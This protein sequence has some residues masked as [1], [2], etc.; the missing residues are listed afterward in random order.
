MT[1]KHLVFSGGG[2]I[3]IQYLAALQEL[4]I[5][6]HIDIANIETIYGTSAGAMLAVIISLKFDWDTINDY[7]IKRPWH[8][9][10]KFTVED[11][12]NAFNT[13]GIF[14]NITIIKCFE[15]LFKAK[16]IPIDITLC[17]FYNITKIELHMFS[18]EINEYKVYDISHKTHPNISV[19]QA[20]QMTC[21]IPSLFKPVYYD[22]FCFIDGG[23]ICN[24][25]LNFCIE[26]GKNPTEIFGFNK[27][28][29]NSNLH[30]NPDSNIF[31][32][33]LNVAFKTFF[34]AQETFIQPSIQNELLCE[35]YSLTIET[36]RDSISNID[37]RNNLF[38]KGKQ[39][40]Y[41][42]LQQSL[43][44]PIEQ[45]NEPTSL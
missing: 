8:D 26:S 11:I 35:D 10:F 16:D 34:K 25:P 36:L 3:L 1:I 2:P 13:Q 23:I 32:L 21:A 31:E 9:V 15:P 24:Y 44:I 30:I 45:K 38:Q 4:I 43:N 29:C 20:I 42:F 17:D 6:K 18:L 27:I 33:I 5:K 40:A 39:Y 22:N 14:D 19:I 28:I 12:F 7:I 41:Y 37:A